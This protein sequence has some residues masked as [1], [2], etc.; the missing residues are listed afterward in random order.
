MFLD[1]WFTNLKT[2]CLNWGSRFMRDRV[3]VGSSTGCSSAGVLYRSPSTHHDRTWLRFHLC[4]DFDTLRFA[5]DDARFEKRF[6]KLRTMYSGLTVIESSTKG[7]LYMIFP[8][9]QCVKP[10]L[11]W[12]SSAVIGLPSRSVAPAT[13][14]LSPVTCTFYTPPSTSA[15]MSPVNGL[16]L[17]PPICRTERYFYGIFTSDSSTDIIFENKCFSMHHIMGGHQ[18]VEVLLTYHYMLQLHLPRYFIVKP[19]SAFVE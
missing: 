18:A 4:G 14:E 19:S 8:R 16:P 3:S 11:T 6:L 10:S 5:T 2:V 17:A 12:R 1:S 7:K 13:D 15:K 9:S